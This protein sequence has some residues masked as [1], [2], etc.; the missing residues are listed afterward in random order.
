MENEGP[1]ETAAPEW[2]IAIKGLLGLGF[3][4]PTG[5]AGQQANI[6]AFHGAPRS[7]AE[8]KGAWG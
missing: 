1:R 2:E 3:C 4:L 5:L 6:L 8:G 7:Y